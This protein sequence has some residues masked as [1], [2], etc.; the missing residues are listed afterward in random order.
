MIGKYNIEVYNKR[1]HYFLTVKR[2]ITVLQGDSATGKTELI[3]LIS[4]YETSGNSSGIILKSDVRCTVLTPVDWELRLNTLK[5]NIIFIDET[6]AFI[7][8]QKFA[9]CVQHSDNYFV[10]VTRDDL[11]ELPYSIDEIYGLKNVSDSSKYKSYKKVYNEMYHLYN[12][13][14]DRK[15]VPDEVITEDTGSGFQCFDLIYNGKC[16]AAGGK[17]RIYNC[18]RRSHAKNL[19]V[20]VDGAA[21][22]CEMSK[23]MRYL[24]VSGKLCVI[25][26][27]ESF[28]YLI[29]KSGILDVSADII[30]RTYL[31]ADS[32]EY[33]SWEEYF[34]AYLIHLTQ[35]TIYQYNKAKLRKSYTTT[36]SLSKMVKVLP[37]AIRFT[38]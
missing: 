23:I 3:R 10:I 6:A 11:A 14:I 7:R 16:K 32:T 37:K 12:L 30:E 2:N 18:I 20:I 33:M 38:G 15:V 28:E 36:G 5:Q 31:Y 26:A 19:L 1:V 29:L 22:G 13:T 34:T 8:T 9:K 25:Y 17:S 21:F 27:P 24:K 4:E 35:N